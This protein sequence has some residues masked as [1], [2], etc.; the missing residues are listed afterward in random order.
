[1]RHDGSLG[2]GRGV[3]L[4]ELLTSY[5]SHQGPLTALEGTRLTVD[6]T[7]RPL[8]PLMST[9]EASLRL[10]DAERVHLVSLKV[11]LIGQT[12]TAEGALASPSG[13]LERA[14]ARRLG[15]QLASVMLER[16]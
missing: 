2:V 14:L 7:R 1:M 15:A 13:G 16:D 10:K 11:S 3:I 8:S 4:S 5:M 6:F 12:A 9:V